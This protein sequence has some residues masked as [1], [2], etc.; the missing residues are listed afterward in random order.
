M[1][2]VLYFSTTP[3]LIAPCGI[4][5]RFCRAFNREKD[6]CPGCR[7]DSVSKPPTRTRCLIKTCEKRLALTGGC[8]DCDEFPCAALSRLDT[9][10]RT[11]YGTSPIANLLV[12][13][14]ISMPAFIN[15]ENLKYSC[16]DCGAL[17]IMH[18][19]HCPS[20]GRAWHTGPLD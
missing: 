3:E 17:L 20:C 19:P 15:L 1:E 12:I 10:Y 4:D 14:D 2:P 8:P 7:A 9:R 6:P 16:P 13:H 5:C 11:K 18:D